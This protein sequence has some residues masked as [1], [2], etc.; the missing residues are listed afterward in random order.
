MAIPSH[1]SAHSAAGGESGKKKAEGTR[2][3]PKRTLIH[4]YFLYLTPERKSGKWRLSGCVGSRSIEYAMRVIARL[5]SS[6]RLGV[7]RPI[8]LP[9]RVVK[10]WSLV[11]L[12]LESML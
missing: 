6:D 12:C 5:L 7:G 8:I 3:F 11:W 2:L 9:A 4:L 1:V 10:R